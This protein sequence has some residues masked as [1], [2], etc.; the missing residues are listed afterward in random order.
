M[1]KLPAAAQEE[2]RRQAVGLRQRG[3][4][5]QA[6]AE[7]VGLSRTGVI[8]ICRRFAAEGA[9]ALA[10]KPRGR[11]PDDQRLLD[12]ARE[13]EL[14]GLIRR[15]TPDELGLP[16]ALWSRAAVRELVARR[17]GVELAVRTA[18]KYLAR[19][20]FTA[21]K[22]L[23]RA[24][25]QDPAAVRR[26]LRRDYPA[27]VARAKQARGIIFWGDETG[28]RSDDVRGRSYAPRGR[29]PLVRVCHRRAKLSLISAVTNRG[30]LRWMVVDGAVNAPTFIR[31][32][33]RL[34]RD[35]RRKVL[36]ILDRLKAHRARLTRDWLAQHRSEIE[37]HYLPPY[38]PEL[39]PDEGVNADLTQSVPRMAPA[40]SQQQL[41][42][43]T[44]SHMR[45]LSKRPKRIRAIFRHQQF[46]YAA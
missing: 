22:P 13:A 42:R 44:I 37:V 31:F 43:A 24:Y 25:E 35:A 19:W 17:C 15:R 12:A 27:I 39:N 29:T 1:R 3:L 26:W 6:V 30:G 8:D 28:L 5:Y 38:S 23:R 21:Q 9:K 4:T 46:R 7:Q 11:K 34:V 2:R 36:L 14:Q 16:F 33:Q 40:R 41:K 45:S 20:G 10:S 18:G 32:L